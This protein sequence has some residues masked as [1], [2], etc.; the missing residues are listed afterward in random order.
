[1]LVFVWWTLSNASPTLKCL[2]R[3]KGFLPYE[4]FKTMSCR[5]AMAGVE[6]KQ[7]I[8]SLNPVSV[9][10]R[11][12]WHPTGAKGRTWD[13]EPS[14]NKNDCFNPILSKPHDPQMFLFSGVHTRENTEGRS[15][16]RAIKCTCRCSADC[17]STVVINWKTIKRQQ[18]KHQHD[19][20]RG[21]GKVNINLSRFG[22][23]GGGIEIKKRSDRT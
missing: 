18:N 23:V 10:I 1:M 6:L 21:G 22:S 19:H 15:K 17:W 14:Q 12:T 8:P 2:S 16:P 20:Y 11:C 3:S 9:W 4:A 13:N 5:C 7:I